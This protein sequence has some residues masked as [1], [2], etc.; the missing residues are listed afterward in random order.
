MR[1][2]QNTEKLVAYYSTARKYSRRQVH[3]AIK[4]L[5]SLKLRAKPVKSNASCVDFACMIRKFF[6]ATF[7]LIL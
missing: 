5:L 7:Q 3:W 2:N 1:Y 6:L 4:T